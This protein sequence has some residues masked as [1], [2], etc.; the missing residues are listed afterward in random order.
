MNMTQTR[1]ERTLLDEQSA[2]VTRTKPRLWR[3]MSSTVVR[4]FVLL[5]VLYAGYSLVRGFSGHDRLPA[6]AHAVRIQ[7]IDIDL[8]LRF[9]WLNRVFSSHAVLGIAGDYW[10]AT[11]HYIVTLTVLVWLFS[12]HRAVYFPARRVLVFATL[13]ALVFFLLL[14][15]APPRM[16]PGY[17]D[18][19][20]LHAH[21]GWWSANASAPRGFGPMANDF[22]AFPSMHAGWSLWVALAVWRATRNPILRFASALYATCT[23]IVVVGT[24]NHW[25]IDVVAGWVIVLAIWPAVFGGFRAHAPAPSLA[26]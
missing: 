5:A 11:M 3:W 16:F 12:K 19:M 14:P 7:R 2:Q 13:V 20:S 9:G 25:S 1:P 10:Y 24:A 26:D 23:A 8:G 17:T 18:V 21:A 4:E 15:T 6:F 22:A